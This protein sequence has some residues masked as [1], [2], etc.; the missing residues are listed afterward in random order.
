[1]SELRLYL[2]RDSLQDGADCTWTLLDAA[3]RVTGSG[4]SLDNL[5]QAR[6]CRLVLAAD[7]VTIG[8]A[9]L[10]RLAARKLAPL[11]PAAAEAFAL[12]DAEQIH[13]VVTAWDSDGR[14]WL[15]ALDKAWL[16]ACLAAL[17]ARAIHAAAALPESLLLPCA[18]GEWS[19]LCNEDGAVA[20]LGPGQALTLD[21]GDPPAGLTLAMGQMAPPRQLRLYQGNALAAAD[22]DA[23]SAVL[24]VPVS[25]AGAWNW[26]TAPWPEVPN[27]LQ[28]PFAP[29]H[30][31][32]DWPS[33]LRPMALGLTALAAIQLLGMLADW[34][35]LAGEQR[36]MQAEMRNLAEQAL[37]AHAAIV[38]PAW[39][40][41]EQLRRQ[42]TGQHLAPDSLPS[43]L[44]RLGKAWP[45]AGSPALQSIAYQGQAMSVQLAKSDAAWL[46]QL[47]DA[48]AAAGLAVSV[49][50][51]GE[52]V[53]LSVRLAADDAAAG[54]GH[55]R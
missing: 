3:G 20:R 10:P 36:A 33:L 19:V 45:A 15:A 25:Y 27:L 2:R 17:R 54:D 13:A 41:A 14:A 50:Q 52:G 37:P 51:A 9:A 49:A 8:S 40:V 47:R 31:R 35:R 34:A 18:P 43:L 46:E 12:A 28:G 1:M 38:D 22:A 53:A 39:Q 16:A 21:K 44:G 7:R 30:T 32:I 23:W 29:A 24:G 42:R 26:R 4:G 55:G 48:A 6:L 5:P 11:L